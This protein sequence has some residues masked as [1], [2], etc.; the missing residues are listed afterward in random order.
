MCSVSI[1]KPSVEI[2]PWCCPLQSYLWLLVVQC[3]CGVGRADS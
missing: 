1:T 3:V 2:P